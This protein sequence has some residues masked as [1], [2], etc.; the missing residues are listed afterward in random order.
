MVGVRPRAS[1]GACFTLADAAFSGL[2]FGSGTV[3]AGALAAGGL[4]A[5]RGASGGRH[6]LHGRPPIDVRPP[7]SG[8]GVPPPSVIVITVRGASAARPSKLAGAKTIDSEEHPVHERRD[9]SH[10][11]Q[12]RRL[13]HPIAQDVADVHR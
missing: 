5:S 12:P 8:P 10:P 7:F 3:I 4:S 1:S 13:V 2:A 11:L 6:F 9:D